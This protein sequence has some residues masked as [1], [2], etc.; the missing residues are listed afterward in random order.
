MKVT[1]EAEARAAK[2]QIEGYAKMLLVAKEYEMEY[3][4]ERI[5]ED[6]KEWGREYKSLTEG[7]V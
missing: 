6:L 3:E 1:K 4:V 2:Q 5:T 7:T